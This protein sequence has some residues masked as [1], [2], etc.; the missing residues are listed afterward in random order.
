VTVRGRN[1]LDDEYEEWA[2]GLMRRLAD[3]RSVEVSAHHRF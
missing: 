1:L 2:S 3:P